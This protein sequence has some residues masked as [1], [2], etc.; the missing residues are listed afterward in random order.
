MSAQT[1][2]DLLNHLGLT[3][4]LEGGGLAVRPKEKITPELR[5]AIQEHKA[6]LMR[7]LQAE[8]A[9]PCGNNQGKPRCKQCSKFGPIGQH[10]CSKP[11]DGNVSMAAL[12]ECADYAGRTVH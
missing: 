12:D 10:G 11:A 5:A 8:T 2:L 9:K 7:L 1:I 6:D 3:A 4:K